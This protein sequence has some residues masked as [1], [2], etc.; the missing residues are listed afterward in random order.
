[1][2]TAAAASATCACR[3][4]SASRGSRT[5]RWATRRRSSRPCTRTARSCSI[6]SSSSPTIPIGRFMRTRTWAF[7]CGA[8]GSSGTAR[9]RRSFGRARSSSSW[10][11]RSTARANASSASRRRWPISTPAREL[12]G[13]RLGQIKDATQP[14]RRIATLRHKEFGFDRSDR[15]HVARTATL[16]SHSAVRATRRSPGRFAIAQLCC[17][18]ARGCPDGPR[19]RPRRSRNLP[20]RADAVPAAAARE[21]LLR[22]AG[23]CPA[24]AQELRAKF[25]GEARTVAGDDV[26]PQ[27]ERHPE[28][29][30]AEGRL[31]GGG[32][33]W[34]C[35]RPLGSAPISTQSSAWT[36]RSGGD[37]IA[38]A[39]RG[40]RAKQLHPGHE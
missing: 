4:A 14:G 8:S 31:T 21:T 24:C 3:P 20:A 30:R 10:S 13:D 28:R 2:R 11:V 32:R 15:L 33:L 39:F 6:I 38:R 22:F 25:A 5:G 29:G 18:H 17:W 12:F 23:P 26:R 40:S 35:R 16:S 7:R 9:R 1:M 19:T 36:R 37:E 27:D 34:R